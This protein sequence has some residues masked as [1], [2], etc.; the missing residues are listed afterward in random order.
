[1]YLKHGYAKVLLG[2]AQGKHEYDKRNAIKKREQDRQ[3]DRV[4]KHY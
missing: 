1:M 3:I 4:M 2:L